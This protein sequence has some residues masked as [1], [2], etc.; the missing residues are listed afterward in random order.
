ME[1][2]V[3]PFHPHDYPRIAKMKCEAEGEQ[4]TVEDLRRYDERWDHSRFE[5]VRVVAQDEEGVA[6]AYGEL[7]HEPDAFD[8]RRYF[9]HLAV[10]T[11]YRRRGVAT[12]IW[13]HL[14]EELA[15]RRATVVRLRAQAL[16]PGAQ[17]AERAGFRWAG[18]DRTRG[19]VLYELR[20]ER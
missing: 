17:W 13:D 14:R 16:G 8:P 7:H 2:K 6:I 9:L 10:D 1:I 11:P 12:A 3:R 15:E 18:E 4:V 19:K 20:P 5:K